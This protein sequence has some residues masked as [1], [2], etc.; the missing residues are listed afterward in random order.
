VPETAGTFL[1]FPALAA[2]GENERST[3]HECLMV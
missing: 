3:R 2:L 1:A